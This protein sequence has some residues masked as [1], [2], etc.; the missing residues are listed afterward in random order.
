MSPVL[1]VTRQAGP[2][3]EPAS[4]NNWDWRSVASD[5]DLILESWSQGFVVG[6]LM[7]MGCITVANMRRGVLLHKLI[8]LEQIM[9]LTH[10]T[11]CFMEFDGY[12]WYLSSTAAL[13]YL[14]YILHNV[15]AWLKIRPFFHGKSTT[16]QPR[17]VKLTT[18]IYIGTLVLTVPPVLF[19][20]S[21]NFRYFNGYS[22][23]YVPVRP[24]EPLMRDPWWVFCCAILF[25]V[26]SKSYGMG[27]VKIIK[28][29]P[30]F[31]ILF[32]SIIL[33]LIFTGLDISAS[34]HSFIGST[35]GINPFWKLSLVF[36]CLTDAILL[37]D[38][39]TELKRLGLKRM[40]RDEKGRQ[41]HALVLDDDD[42]LN[43]DDEAYMH[44]SNGSISGPVLN[45]HA[46]RHSVS[47]HGRRK[48]D[49]MEG[50]E[51]VEFMQALHTHPSQLSSDRSSRRSSSIRPQTGTGGVRATK[52]PSLFQTIK[53][54]KKSRQSFGRSD[55]IWSDQNDDVEAQ[56]K[57][58]KKKA[59]EDDNIAPDQITFEDD[60]LE[61]ARRM[62][63]ATIAEL[64]RRKDSKVRALDADDI[65]RVQQQKRGAPPRDFWDE[66][67]VLDDH[68]PSSSS[69]LRP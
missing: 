46:F 43:S 12:G 56:S 23:W 17:F 26:I 10:G 62:N 40:K 32:A 38:F 9:A 55:S 4:K 25:Y 33:A 52:L 48:S 24:Y 5:E 39:K 6:S 28:K 31:G 64:T 69:S 22:G 16:F 1:L 54:G 14:S 18:R 51:Q 42:R 65:S 35:D 13:L 20:I 15:V 67:D 58:S 53:P 7:L 37:D 21:D 41:S 11:F 49:D 34:I 63:E 60:S 44:Y 29:S 59:H 50:S 2:V 45:G 30:R 68:E 27:V 61:R 19:Q 36:K 8:F 47:H 66:I 57:K 3:I